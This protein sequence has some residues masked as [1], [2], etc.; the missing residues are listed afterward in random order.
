MGLYNVE[1]SPHVTNPVRC[2]RYQELEHGKG[3]CKGKLKRLSVERKT[4][5]ALIATMT[6]CVVTAVSL[7]WLPPRTVIS[8]K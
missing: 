3:Q 5:K 1:V 2:F 8:S 6:S 4:M 7:T